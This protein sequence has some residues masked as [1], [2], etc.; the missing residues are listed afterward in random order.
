MAQRAVYDFFP[1]LI[2]AVIACVFV[3][4]TLSFRSLVLALKS[5]LSIAAM[6]VCVYGSGTAIFAR[7]VMD[8]AGSSVFTSQ[9]GGL[10]WCVCRLVRTLPGRALLT[11]PAL[12]ALCRAECPC[13]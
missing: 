5:V 7:G 8:G 4:I 13:V 11:M 6:V 9:Q 12:H 2:G 10:M 1:A 3:I